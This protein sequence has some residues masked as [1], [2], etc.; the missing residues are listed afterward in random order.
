MAL[1]GLA[2]EERV[3]VEEVPVPPAPAAQLP[4]AP[5][6][7][8]QAT[9]DVLEGTPGDAGVLAEQLASVEQ[10]LVAERARTQSALERYREALLAAE[11]ELPPDLV[12]GGTLEELETSVDAARRAVA[13]IRERLAAVEPA[14]TVVPAVRGFPIGAP[15]RG[16]AF[17]V[18][19]MSAAEKIAAGLR[20]RAS[21]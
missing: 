12:R 16:S 1:G 7:E 20:A 11:P 19:S 2:I 3:A 8:A 14:V 4:D 13:R 10:A 6:P 18:A 17:A 15:V 5:S 9:V 21:A